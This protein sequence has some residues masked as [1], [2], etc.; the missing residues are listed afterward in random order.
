M[1]FNKLGSVL[2]I[3]F[4]LFLGSSVQAELDPLPHL[5]FQADIYGSSALET[6]SY[7]SD[8][9]FEN[10]GGFGINAPVFISG[11]RSGDGVMF[12]VSNS[13]AAVFSFEILEDTIPKTISVPSSAYPNGEVEALSS[14]KLHYVWEIEDVNFHVKL[15][16]YAELVEDER[17][18]GGYH[19]REQFSLENY[20]S[21]FT[22][23]N[24][25]E[26][27][28]MDDR[29]STQDYDCDGLNETLL[30]I[31]A[32]STNGYPIFGKKYEHQPSRYTKISTNNNFAT[33][34]TTVNGTSGLEFRNIGDKKNISSAT[35]FSSVAKDATL[36]E[37]QITADAKTLIGG[38]HFPDRWAVRT[39]NTDDRGAVFINGLM[40]AGSIYSLYPDSGWLNVCGDWN[41]EKDN[42][43]SF[44]SFDLGI[45]CHATYGFGIKRNE[46]VVWSDQGST[47]TDLGIT[48][49]RIVKV[50][51]QGAISDYEQSP[52][53]TTLDGNWELTIRANGG[54][55]FALTDKF[56]V[57]GSTN[58]S[59]QTINITDWL[60]K[61]ANHIHLNAWS[62]GNG[63][64]E[65]YFA[66]SKNGDILWENTKQL[67]N[68][69]RGRSKYIHLIIDED[70]NI[71][72]FPKL[73]LPFSYLPRS[74]RSA[75]MRYATS[76]F[77]HDLPLGFASE[78]GNNTVTSYLGTANVSS[79]AS[80]ITSYD[81]HDG[82]DF[83]GLHVADGLV[84]APA[85]GIVTW[86][87]DSNQFYSCKLDGQPEFST[88]SCMATIDHGNGFQSR[89]VHLKGVG[90]TDIDPI[91]RV[92]TT[93]KEVQAGEPIGQ[94][95]NTGCSTGE[96][97]HMEVRLNNVRF[98]PSGWLGSEEDP[99]EAHTNGMASLNIWDFSVPSSE[100]WSERNVDD[101]I[102]LTSASNTSVTI[103]AGTFSGLWDFTYLDTPVAEPDNGLF[104][105]G[106]SFIFEGMP[107]SQLSTNRNIASGS[108]TISIPYKN[109]EVSQ[110][111]EKTLQIYWWNE[112]SKVWEELPT[113]VDTT[114][115]TSVTTINRFGLFAL[116]SKGH[117]NF[118][119]LPVVV[120]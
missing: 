44:A 90:G 38:T 78:D 10:H 67:E 27:L 101:G 23:L 45:C 62:D 118:Q 49:Q 15:H 20:G 53:P 29:V 65:W 107:A 92:D 13:P 4:I 115:K 25:S 79:T 75:F 57:A 69:S 87:Y 46:E 88:R 1:K 112:E 68:T 51:K 105:T 114:S 14:T 102:T 59:T 64:H 34:E 103:P 84:R 80:A 99:W 89:F 54:F 72:S 5:S 108:F 33:V 30:A 43:I 100:Q 12:A 117:T 98:D 111:H 2:L 96:H 41:K 74:P 19:V 95:G 60:G 21:P 83:S 40:V 76:V 16:K 36:A 81:Q 73:N 42:F 7:R 106:H 120:R 31:N 28:H 66:I 22:L 86:K 82:Y 63:N 24:F 52:P 116:F 32:F 47:P 9:D 8:L 97:I 104:S 50:S 35:Y 61:Q 119:Y 3:G 110:L 39:H 26:V 93:G 109:T 55:A 85:D 18:A 71:N 48:Y 37:Q 77:D 56:P 113:S 70:G 58:N 94:I 17:L 91:C 11:L 6:I